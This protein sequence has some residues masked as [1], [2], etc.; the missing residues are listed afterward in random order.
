MAARDNSVKEDEDY[1]PKKRYSS[2]EVVVVRMPEVIDDKV[3]AGKTSKKKADAPYTTLAQTYTLEE[4][5]RGLIHKPLPN[6]FEST[7][8][9]YTSRLFV[10]DLYSTS[11]LPKLNK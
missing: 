4:L 6:K 2:S 1:E 8:T 3:K 7:Q 11:T 5:E 9:V 10:S